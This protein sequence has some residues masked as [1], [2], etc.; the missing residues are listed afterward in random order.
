MPFLIQSLS[1][2]LS[3]TYC[4]QLNNMSDFYKIRRN[5]FAENCTANMSFVKPSLVKTT[6]YLRM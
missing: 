1:V 4:P 5:C 6:P 3:L 2:R